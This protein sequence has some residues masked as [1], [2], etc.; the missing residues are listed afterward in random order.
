MTGGW[1]R[2]SRAP[3]SEAKKA[4]VLS[5]IEDKAVR[6]RLDSAIAT[7]QS[8][9]A[10]QDEPEWDVWLA[11]IANE[12]S[13]KGIFPAIYISFDKNPAKARMVLDAVLAD[14]KDLNLG[15]FSDPIAIF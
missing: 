6:E 8:A 10:A 5:F 13:V 1:G 14:R 12:K 3:V 2:T 11:K 4:E 7:V 9:G 15:F